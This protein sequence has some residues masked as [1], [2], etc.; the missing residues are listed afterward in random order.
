MEVNTN[1]VAR[2]QVSEERWGIWKEIRTSSS[3]MGG[4]KFGTENSG[5]AG[6]ESP[7]YLSFQLPFTFTF[8]KN[9]PLDQKLL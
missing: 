5:G 2:W 4:C 9:M 1:A 8:T 7:P 6:S 3:E